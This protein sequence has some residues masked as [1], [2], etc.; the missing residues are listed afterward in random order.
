MVFLYLEDRCLEIKDAHFVSE[1]LRG[2]EWIL[3]HRPYPRL[4]SLRSFSLGLLK[5]YLSEAL[6][7]FS[8]LFGIAAEPHPYIGGHVACYIGGHVA[9]RIAVMSR[10]GLAVMGRAPLNYL[11]LL[12]LIFG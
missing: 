9:C 11:S 1:P 6:S 12:L 10:V 2:S 4:H 5:V 3:C 8:R 7:M